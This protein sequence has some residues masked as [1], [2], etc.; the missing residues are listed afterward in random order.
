MSAPRLSPPPYSTDPARLAREV[1]VETCRAGGPGGQHRNVTDSAVRLLHRPS[2]V[3]VT[4]SESR[5]QHR[6]RAVAWERLIAKLER[7]N[8]V[9]ATRVP[10]RVSKGAVERRLV[11][12]KRRQASK[13]LR[14]RA[15]D[16]D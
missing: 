13:R 5:S 10:T 14:A 15:Q 16:D 3:Q 7:L 4:A 1:I 6:N 12:K 8:R 9:P 11:E 2:G